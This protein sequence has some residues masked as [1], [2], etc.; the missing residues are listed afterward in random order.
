MSHAQFSS[1]DIRFRLNKSSKFFRTLFSDAPRM[2]VVKI[3]VLKGMH[4]IMLRYIKLNHIT[5]HHTTSDCMCRRT[6]FKDNLQF[7]Q[8]F[9]A[10]SA[11]I[12]YK[13]HTIHVHMA[14]THHTEYQISHTIS[15]FNVHCDTP[16]SAMHACTYTYKYT[17][18]KTFTQ[19]SSAT[20]LLTHSQ[21][22]S[23]Y[24]YRWLV[25]IQ[26]A[27][28]CACMR[29]DSQYVSMYVYRWHGQYVC[30]YAYRQ[31]VCV[32]VCVQIASMCVCMLIDG[33]Y[34][35]MC[36]YS[37]GQLV[38][39]HVCVQ[40]ASCVHVCVQI[41]SMCACMHTDGQYVFMYAYRQLV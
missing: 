11:Y 28:I 17:R 40:I 37:L 20:S 3:H 25:C 24:A 9:A 33:Q 29:T 27:S 7:T 2:Y 30:M 36:A 38:C 39:A 22:V 8:V 16:I 41:A 15:H 23:M 32:H 34:A 5:P 26:M 13:I 14:Y 10:V 12:Q 1:C 18:T 19:H 4:H 21:Y 31:L 6:L 35:L